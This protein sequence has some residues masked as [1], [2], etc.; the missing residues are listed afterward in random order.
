[1]VIDDLHVEDIALIPDKKDPPLVINADAVLTDTLPVK[2]F[3]A[4]GRRDAEVIQGSGIIEH[5]QFA[6]SH[7]LDIPRYSPGA[8]PLPD[9]LSFPSAEALDHA[10]TIT[11]RVI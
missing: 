8:L 3:E 9:L 5:S 2:R 1:M 4:V 6:P 10:S 11:Y 7:L